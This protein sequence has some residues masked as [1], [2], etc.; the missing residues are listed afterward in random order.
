MHYH[1]EGMQRVSIGY[2]LMTKQTKQFNEP[3]FSV[4]DWIARAIENWKWIFLLMLAGAFIGCLASY[5]R[6]DHYQAVAEVLVDQNPEL[7]LDPLVL[8]DEESYERFLESQTQLLEALSKS[9]LVMD[10]IARDLIGRGYVINDTDKKILLENAILSHP[11]QGKW[12]FIVRDKNPALAAECANAWA[13]AFIDEAHHAIDAA[14][15]L[16]DHRSY[17]ASISIRLAK[18]YARCEAV[19]QGRADVEGMRNGIMAQS[20]EEQGQLLF[21]WQMEE[22][23]ARSGLLNIA[24]LSDSNQVTVGEQLAYLEVL[25]AILAQDEES[26][27]HVIEALRTE[28]REAIEQEKVLSQRGLGVDSY[29]ELNLIREAIEPVEPFVSSG[30]FVAIGGLIGFLVGFAWAYFRANNK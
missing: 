17:V 24:N 6:S 4:L 15:A 22:I 29:L 10:A 1:V 21:T 8:H 26:C 5:F 9:D 28:W 25:E 7:A 30:L 14:I 16:R 12:S 18:E 11:A 13:F 2:F 20:P 3:E 27:P 23:A 19:H